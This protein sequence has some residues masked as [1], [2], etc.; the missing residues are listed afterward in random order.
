MTAYGL[1]CINVSVQ[2][3]RGMIARQA[4]SPITRSS[5]KGLLTLARK[6]QVAEESKR[7]D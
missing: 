5:R 6:I 3:L 4:P 1:P 2:G 7:Q